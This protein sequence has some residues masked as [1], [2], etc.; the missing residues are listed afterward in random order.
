MN[1]TIRT[2]AVMAVFSMMT[3][4]C[5]KEVMNTQTVVSEIG[6]VYTVSY[7]VDGVPQ[8]ETLYGD[9][10]WSVFLQR[11]FALAEE[12]HRVIFWNGTEPRTGISKE[13]VTYTTT[14]EDDAME[15][16]GKMANAGYE[17]IVTYD[18]ETGIFTCTAI[19]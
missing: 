18:E 17:V 19:K 5:Q 14:S 11:M 9:D 3:A 1:K 8:T 15:W 4:G 6:S 2:I 10:A 7:V 16:A 12:G 13:I